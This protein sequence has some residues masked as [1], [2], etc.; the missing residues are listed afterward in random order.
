LVEELHRK[1]WLISE[2]SLTK[3]TIRRNQILEVNLLFAKSR[4]WDACKMQTNVSSIQQDYA[5]LHKIQ[6]D[7][8]TFGHF[9]AKIKQAQNLRVCPK[10]CARISIAGK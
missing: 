7:N 2:N 8:F 1:S 5:L 6:P 3:K 4:S 10:F 9:F